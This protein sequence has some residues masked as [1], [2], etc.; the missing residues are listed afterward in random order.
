LTGI[1]EAVSWWEN[2]LEALRMACFGLSVSLNGSANRAYFAAFYA[3]SGILASQGI[4][5]KKHSAIESAVHRD[6]VNTGKWNT[7]L[8]ANYSKLFAF[9]L[10]GDYGNMLRV[11]QKQAE[12]AIEYALSIL[13]A[14]SK[15][16]PNL[17]ALP[18][19]HL[20]K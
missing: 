8:G 9:R 10:V 6:F 14:V 18:E 7:E 12:N 4:E 5:Y 13:E 2:A 1:P 17:F 19:K 20:P 11:A 16:R 15:E 3:V